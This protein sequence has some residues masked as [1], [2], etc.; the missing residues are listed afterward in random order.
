[1]SGRRNYSKHCSASYSKLD[2]EIAELL[3]GI[4]KSKAAI[5]A[6]EIKEYKKMRETSGM[7]EKLKVKRKMEGIFCE[8]IVLLTAGSRV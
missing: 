5:Q 2:V 4:L 1:M 6:I 3:N 8:H 7:K